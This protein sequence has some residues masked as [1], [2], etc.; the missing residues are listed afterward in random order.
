MTGNVL[1]YSKNSTKKNPMDPTKMPM[2]TKVG[3]NMLQL[4]GK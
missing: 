4:E 1:E 2:S 3:E